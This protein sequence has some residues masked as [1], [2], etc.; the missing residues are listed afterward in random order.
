SRWDDLHGEA[1]REA[2][3]RTHNVVFSQ[4]A[5]IAF[6][7]L[8]CGVDGARVRS[9]VTRKCRESQLGEAQVQELLRDLDRRI[10]LSDGDPAD[11]GLQAYS[12][13][14]PA[15][16]DKNPPRTGTSRPA[17]AA[18][19]LGVSP[20]A[21]AAAAA[22]VVPSASSAKT[23]AAFAAGTPAADS[24]TAVVPARARSRSAAAGGG[25]STTALAVAAASGGKFGKFA[26]S[27]AAVAGGGGS[28]VVDLP[29]AV[30]VDTSPL[31]AA[32]AAG[33]NG[34][35]PTGDLEPGLPNVVSELIR[36]CVSD[37]DEYREDAWRAVVRLALAGAEND[38]TRTGGSSSGEISPLPLSKAA[39]TGAGASA[40]PPGVTSG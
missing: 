30:P 24:T 16:D 36:V 13:T 7:M 11:E 20:A 25:S 4:L 28:V 32:A 14:S 8:E 35:S 17:A 5:S 19:A 2:V 31:N 12:L 10:R 6:N 18:S 37:K 22:G 34:D 9:D 39:A 15:S 38:D 27:A 23:K 26:P 40:G 1:R 3:A 29:R 33:P 21:A